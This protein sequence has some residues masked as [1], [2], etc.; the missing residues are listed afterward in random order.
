MVIQVQTTVQIDRLF[1]KV[2]YAFTRGIYLQKFV[3]A[4]NGIA[5]VALYS[6]AQSLKRIAGAIGI[7]CPGRMN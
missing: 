3:F 6:T 5:R 7:G 1:H 4:F 2:N